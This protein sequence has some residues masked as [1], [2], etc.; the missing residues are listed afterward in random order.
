MSGA[1]AKSTSAVM[2]F[3]ISLLPFGSNAQTCDERLEIDKA[4]YENKIE[5]DFENCGDNEECLKN[6]ANEAK[7][8]PYLKEY[9]ECKE[10]SEQNQEGYGDE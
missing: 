4:A 10:R 6:V 1:L 7:K 5:R 9:K 8:H 3:S 2:F